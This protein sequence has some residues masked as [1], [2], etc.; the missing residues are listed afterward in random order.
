MSMPA[1]HAE[2]G[3]LLADAHHA[4]PRLHP[5]AVRFLLVQVVGRQAHN[6]VYLQV[7]GA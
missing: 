7:S 5:L 3:E 2:G 6:C 4:G 1:T